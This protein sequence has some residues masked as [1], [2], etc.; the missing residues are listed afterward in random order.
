MEKTSDASRWGCAPVNNLEAVPFCNAVVV[1]WQN[2]GDSIY[3]HWVDLAPVSHNNF[4]TGFFINKF[5]APGLTST[6]FTNLGYTGW[7]Y[8]REYEDGTYE[9]AGNHSFTDGDGSN[10]SG[11]F[12][13]QLC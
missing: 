3:G 2:S 1:S 11:K 8:V 5:V 12:W 7:W 4:H 13:A 9:D 10:N 6:T